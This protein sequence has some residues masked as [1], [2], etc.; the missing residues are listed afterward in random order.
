MKV[1]SFLCLHVHFCKHVKK[2]FILNIWIVA[3]ECTSWQSWLD[4]QNIC[5]AGMPC[6][7]SEQMAQHFIYCKF[8]AW[9]IFLERAFC[10]CQE[11]ADISLQYFQQV[12]PPMIMGT[13]RNAN[14]WGLFDV[15]KRFG[16][17]KISFWHPYSKILSRCYFG[18][19]TL[20]FSVFLNPI[21]TF[22]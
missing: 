9:G 4:M 16:I 17:S 19:C 15:C 18:N 7:I 5:Y 10:Y 21:K 1:L 6:A 2:P 20:Y 3:Y 13:W 12:L 11:H 22:I 8:R 14:C